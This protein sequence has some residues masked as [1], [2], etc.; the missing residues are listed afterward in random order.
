MSFFISP[1]YTEKFDY[2]FDTKGRISVPAEWRGEPFES[3]LVAWPG[4]DKQR[5]KS[6]ISVHPISWL[7]EA[8]EKTRK[9]PSQDSRRRAFE[10]LAVEMQQFTWDDQGRINVRESL[11][12]HAGIVRETILVGGVD[13][14]ELWSP[15]FYKSNESEVPSRMNDALEE[16]GI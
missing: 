7:H 14:F 10:R 13:H 2:S 11:R 3:R 1:F 4:F 9:L 8:V 5:Q 16:L 15:E 6:Y 12:K